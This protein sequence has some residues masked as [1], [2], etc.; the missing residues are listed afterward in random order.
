MLS[1]FIGDELKPTVR[2]L[3]ISRAF[4]G[5]Y[6]LMVTAPFLRAQFGIEFPSLPSETRPQRQRKILDRYPLVPSLPPAF[7]IP[8]GPLGFSVPGDNYLLRHQTLMMKTGFFSPSA[9]Q[10]SCSAMLTTT[11][12]AHRSRSRPWW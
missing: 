6:L 2:R 7:T 4:T 11:Q 8:V 10:D 1:T 3:H 9:C 12:K 5:L